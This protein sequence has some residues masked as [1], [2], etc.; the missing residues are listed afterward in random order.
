MQAQNMD[1]RGGPLTPKQKCSVSF[2]P[3][4]KLCD[5]T[6]TQK[7]SQEWNIVSEKNNTKGF[8]SVV[9]IEFWKNRCLSME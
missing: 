3:K 2:P 1:P 8:E 6:Q 9:K 5:C 4:T 7:K